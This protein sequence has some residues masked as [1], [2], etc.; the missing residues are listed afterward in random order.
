M[1]E[2]M[3][4]ITN[5][6]GK[7]VGKSSMSAIY[8][9]NLPDASSWI[10][11]HHIEIFLNVIKKKNKLWMD[12]NPMYMVSTKTVPTLFLQNFQLR[13]GPQQ[14]NLNFLPSPVRLDDRNSLNLISS[15]IFVQDIYK[16]VTST[17]KKFI[18]CSSNVCFQGVQ[19]NCTHI[20]FVDF[21]SF[22]RSSNKF[23]LF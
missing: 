13:R 23:G 7:I 18:I 8:I 11:I 17:W 10:F 12:N 20:V 14:N 21:S 1:N 19:K 5:C 6:V 9:L 15:C 3:K 2:W 16:N 22:L 4:G